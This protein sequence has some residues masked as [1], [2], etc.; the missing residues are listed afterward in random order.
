M[1]VMPRGDTCRLQTLSFPP[2]S[3]STCQTKSFNLNNTVAFAFAC[4]LL[5]FQVIFVHL[6]LWTL[7]FSY[8]INGIIIS[9]LQMRKP[10]Q[11]NQG[12]LPRAQ[13]PWLAKPHLAGTKVSWVTSI[14]VWLVI[15][16][17]LHSSIQWIFNECLL[18]SRE[19]NRPGTS[20]HG[21]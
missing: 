6:V 4:I 2:K 20:P 13:S 16:Y 17:F 7:Q 3:L 5:I 21:V 12:T 11:K 10:K 1:H 18:Y 9:H 8:E 14:L 19:K 15:F